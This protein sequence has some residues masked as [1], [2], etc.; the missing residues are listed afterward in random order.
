[1]S[2]L[3]ELD[4]LVRFPVEGQ[5]V[6]AGGLKVDFGFEM[7]MHRMDQDEFDKV[8]S[9]LNVDTKSIV[10]REARGWK[11]VMSREG[12]A[13]PYSQEAFRRLITIPG[14]VN[15]IW[16]AYCNHAGVQAKNSARSSD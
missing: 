1:M 3:I 4:D 13:V 2:I 5:L 14:L 10:L 7:D 16:I 15:M 9:N 6:D 11:G 12:E 8:L